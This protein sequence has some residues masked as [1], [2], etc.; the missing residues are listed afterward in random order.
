MG[1]IEE[2]F[3]PI[4]I[5]GIETHYE[6]S[7]KGNVRNSNTGKILQPE[8]S[9]CGYLRVGM[10]VVKNNRRYHIHGSVHRLVAIAFIPNPDNL[11][12]VNHKDGNKTHNWVEN[13]EWSSPSDNDYHAFATGLK[14]QIYGENSHL[15]KYSRESVETACK[16]MESGK[17]LI[18]EISDITE[19]PR[20]MLYRIRLHKSWCNVSKKYHIENCKV[21]A[22]CH[23]ET[24]FSMAQMREV[25]RLLSENKLS[26][27]DISDRTRVSVATIRNVVTHRKGLKQYES[28]YDEYD[29]SNY[30]GRK[31]V[32][33]PLTNDHKK[34]IEF[35][36]NIN[37]PVDVICSIMHAEHNYNSQYIRDYIHRKYKK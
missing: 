30:K 32:L 22:V 25:F 1:I 12:E 4:F 16:L 35:L 15:H 19:I 26:V 18:K 11:P 2:I 21:P 10:Y 31:Q 9:N 29:V 7:N 34:Q 36:I 6:V 3:K 28:L 5:N 37:K 13:L 33:S 20:V 23:D 17:Y 14:K 27:Y 24:R 8:V